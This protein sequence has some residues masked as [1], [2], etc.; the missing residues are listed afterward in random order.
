[1]DRAKDCLPL[2]IEVYEKKTARTST[3]LKF[4]IIKRALHMTLLEWLWGW[5]SLG[6][7]PMR[8]DGYCRIY[9]SSQSENICPIIAKSIGHNGGQSNFEFVICWSSLL[10]K[11]LKEFLI[12]DG[13]LIRIVKKDSKREK[14]DGFELDSKF[15]KVL[16]AH[17]LGELCKFSHNRQAKGECASGLTS[18]PNPWN[19]QTNNIIWA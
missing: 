16:G 19:K 3:N 7:W 14:P 1:M 6:S 13:I 11:C 18:N 2:E 5:L 9:G 15:F 4:C 17:D 8:I 12:F 10:K